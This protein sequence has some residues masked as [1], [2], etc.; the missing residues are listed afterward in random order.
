MS[1]L[2]S[3][4]SQEVINLFETYLSGYI[5]LVAKRYNL[6]K[7]ELREMFS[8]SPTP[9]TESKKPKSS[10]TVSELTNINMS[11]LSIERLTSCN[12]NELVALCKAKGCKCS[13]TK[14]VLMNRLLGKEEVPKVESKS[15]LRASKAIPTTATIKTG[16]TDNAP[17]I[18]KIVSNIDTI[19]IRWNKFGNLEHPP[20]RI[21]FN[22]KTHKA[23]GKQEDNGVIT[24]LTSE[25]I[26]QCD[27]YK[28]EYELPKSLDKD[29]LEQV[30]IAELED[31][32]E[33]VVEESDDSDVQEED[34]DAEIVE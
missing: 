29:N 12:K 32:L 9:F 4:F 22:R 21:V 13:G 16:K 25:D 3:K 24:E 17:V 2:K 19:M 27:K 31:D 5:D 20:T 18:A 11:D 15:P 7:E 23:M 28:F 8:G 1:E 26:E 33:V 34:G 10:T 14:E 30:K 6:D